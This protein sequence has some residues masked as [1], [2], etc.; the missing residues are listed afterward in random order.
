MS[1]ATA[2]LPVLVLARDLLL[3]SRVTASAAAVGVSCRLVRDPAK[4][5]EAAGERLIADL[6]LPGALEAATAWRA[7]TQ[8]P[9]VGF[10]AHVDP[11]VLRSARIAGLERVV[12]RGQ[13]VQM[14]DQLMKGPIE[15]K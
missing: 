10:A 9:V 11:E 6:N 8:R 13:L 3:G 5:A 7:A 1:E 2:E 4:L 15:S 12:T 14:L